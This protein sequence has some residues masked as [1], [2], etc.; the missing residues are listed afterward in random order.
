MA[1]EKHRHPG[2][3]RRGPSFTHELC[4]GGHGPKQSREALADPV[5]GFN[6]QQTT[7]SEVMEA[8]LASPM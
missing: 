6:R 3:R 4:G 7:E 1:K 8:V 2:V 5:W